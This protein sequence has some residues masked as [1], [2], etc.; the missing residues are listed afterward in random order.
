MATRKASQVAL[1]AFA[2]VL[3]ELV[4]GSA[5]L[6]G[7]NN[8]LHKYS[9]PLTPERRGR[10]LSLLRRT[11]VRHGR[12]DERPGRA[13]RRHSVRRHVPRLLGLRAQR[14]AHGGADRA[15]QHLRAD[16]RLDRPRRGRPDAPAD[17]ASREPAAHAE[18]GRLAAVRHRRDGRRLARRDRASERADVPRADAAG[19]AARAAHAGADRS[20]R[21]RRVHRQQRRRAAGRSR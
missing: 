19:S 4:G 5:D 16:A 15:A 8:T 3:P 10:Q 1:E 20:R 13:W 2:P 17:R 12:D 9:K 18:H 11:R 14:A 21:A 7:S 6:T